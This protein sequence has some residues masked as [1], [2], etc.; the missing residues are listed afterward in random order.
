MAVPYGSFQ[1]KAVGSEIKKYLFG[2]YLLSVYYML[3]IVLN[4]E[5]TTVNKT[6]NPINLK[7]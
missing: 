3:N 1:Q 4:T 5:D 2:K 7:S 6:K